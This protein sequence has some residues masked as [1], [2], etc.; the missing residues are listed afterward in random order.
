MPFF[1]CRWELS[2]L[3]FAGFQDL[4]ASSISRVKLAPTVKRRES[5]FPPTEE[6]DALN[7]EK[8]ILTISESSLKISQTS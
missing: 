2:E 4:R 5:E 6:L 7:Q 1:S 8:K 3:G